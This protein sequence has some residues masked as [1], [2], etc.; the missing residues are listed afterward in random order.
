M[1]LG[2][3]KNPTD[4]NTIESAPHCEAVSSR[5]LAKQPKGLDNSNRVTSRARLGEGPQRTDKDSGR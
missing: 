1:L 5:I 4:G 3:P 2:Y